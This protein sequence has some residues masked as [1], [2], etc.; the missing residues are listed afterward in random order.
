MK[1]FESPELDSKKN[2]NNNN[3]RFNCINLPNWTTYA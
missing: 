3:R 1:I 2:N